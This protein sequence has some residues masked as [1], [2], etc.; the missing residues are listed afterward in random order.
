VQTDVVAEGRLRDF[1]GLNRAKHVVVEAAILATRVVWLPPEE[2]RESLRRLAVLVEKTGGAAEHRAFA[3]LND[4][5]N[6]M[7]GRNRLR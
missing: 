2:I 1:F 7:L 5:V 4:Y 3:M 6:E